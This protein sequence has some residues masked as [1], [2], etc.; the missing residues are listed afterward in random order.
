MWSP[1]SRLS[2]I[3][4]A[5]KFTEPSVVFPK[6]WKKYV[7]LLP[8]LSFHCFSNKLYGADIK[9]TRENVPSRPNTHTAPQPLSKPAVA[10]LT[11]RARCQ[12]YWS[13]SVKDSCNGLY[14]QLASFLRYDSV[15]WKD[16][17]DSGDPSQSRRPEMLKERDCCQGLFSW[18]AVVLRKHYISTYLP[19]EEETES[20]LD[21]SQ[22]DSVE[23]NHKVHELLSVCWNQIH[24]LAHSASP[25][26][27]AVYHQ[28]L[29]WQQRRQRRFSPQC[30]V[31][32]VNLH[33]CETLQTI[34]HLSRSCSS[35]VCTIFLSG[36][37]DAF[38]FA[39]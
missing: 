14:L 22:P 13:E 38:V 11:W 31:S 24:N 34:I 32:T 39:T 37:R 12:G 2:S 9:R 6:K 7:F 5:S 30:S 17:D 26:G 27:C 33:P 36:R 29:D 25:P 35:S 3:K 20:N 18:N 10:S 1:Y 28:R 15:E 16:E 4:L 8:T 21:G 23:V 19:E